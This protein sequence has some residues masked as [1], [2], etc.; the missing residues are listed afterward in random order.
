[1]GS[2]IT[3]MVANASDLGI[4]PLPGVEALVL[5]PDYFFIPEYTQHL[6]EAKELFEFLIS[7]EA[8][9]LQ[10]AQ[11]GH[12][13][14]NI[15]VPLTSYPAADKMVIEFIKDYAIAPD[16]DD[17]I[18]G[19]FQSTLFDQLKLLWVDPTKLNEVLAAIQAVAP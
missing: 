6:D 10:T 15:N 4:I 12:I 13:A 5:P 8:Q 16:V 7:E 11:G 3:G 9:R 1:M 14:T 17:T 19:E 2:W 18:G